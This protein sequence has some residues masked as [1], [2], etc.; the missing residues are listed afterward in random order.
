[1]IHDEKNQERL[2]DMKSLRY[3]GIPQTYSRSSNS[4]DPEF[5]ELFCYNMD[6]SCSPASK[7]IYDLV[8]FQFTNFLFA[9]HLDHVTWLATATQTCGNRFKNS[10]QVEWTD[11]GYEVTIPRDPS[12]QT[13]PLPNIHHRCTTS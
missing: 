7:L 10:H 3:N 4:N 11:Q 8:F 1:M 2:H 12:L 9:C 5:Y 13:L 6:L